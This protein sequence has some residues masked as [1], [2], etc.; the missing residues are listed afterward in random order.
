LVY[1]LLTSPDPAIFSVPVSRA[2]D[3]LVAIGRINRPEKGGLGD[4]N[5]VIH[6]EV[7]K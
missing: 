3:R 5:K 7:V 2:S 4:L 1:Q 6:L